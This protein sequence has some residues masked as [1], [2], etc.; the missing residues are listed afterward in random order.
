[1]K[2][3]KKEERKRKKME[4]RKVRRKE[5]MKKGRG[6]RKKERNRR[7]GGINLVSWIFWLRSQLLIKCLFIE[8]LN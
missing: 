3:R 1:M 4:K 2:G 8:T 5:K 7:R 6:G